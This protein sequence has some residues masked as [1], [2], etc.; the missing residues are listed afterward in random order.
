MVAVVFSQPI[1]S[2]ALVLVLHPFATTTWRCIM[3][4]VIASRS[5]GDSDVHRRRLRF[6][7]I[8]DDHILMNDDR[9]MGPC[10]SPGGT[11]GGVGGGAPPPRRILAGVWARGRRRGGP[12]GGGW[13][14]PNHR[15]LMS[16]VVVVGDPDDGVLTSTSQLNADLEHHVAGETRLASAAPRPL[17]TSRGRSR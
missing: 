14:A 5:R 12:R 17:I 2:L 16:T 1:P 13:G 6:I 10:R 15:V 9:R 11:T 4:V 3:V 7:L 8:N